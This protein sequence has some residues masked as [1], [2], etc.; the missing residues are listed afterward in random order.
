MESYIG[1]KIIQ[2][3]LMDECTFLSTVKKQ[4]VSDRE[5][6]AG[7]KVIYPDGYISWSPKSVFEN[8]YR[9][10]TNKEKHL[11]TCPE[12]FLED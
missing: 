6:R 5:T 8:A 4:D 7:Y 9:L 1:S 12:S 3:E 11:I 2:A 10:V